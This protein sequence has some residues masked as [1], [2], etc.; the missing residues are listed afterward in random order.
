MNK[1]IKLK[2]KAKNK[3]YKQYIKNR[4]FGSDFVF[5][6]CLVNEINDLISNAK[7]LYYDNLAKNETIHC[8]KQKPICQFLKHFTT[9]KN[10]PLIPPLLIDDKFVTDIQAKVNIFNKFFVD[11]NTLRNTLRK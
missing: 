7:N 9:K 8:C 4:R 5:I 3:L 10:I 2:I 1:I 11:Q 6:E